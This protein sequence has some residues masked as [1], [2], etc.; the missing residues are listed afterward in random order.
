MIRWLNQILGLCRVHSI[1][2]WGEHLLNIR[3]VISKD[4][5]T[6]LILGINLDNKIDW[7]KYLPWMES[8]TKI[9][10]GPNHSL[11]WASSLPGNPAIK[12]VFS[13]SEK[14]ILYLSLKPHRLCSLSW[15]LWCFSEK[16]EELSLLSSTFSSLLFT[17]ETTQFFFFFFPNHSILTPFLTEA[18]LARST[19]VLCDGIQSFSFCLINQ[20]SSSFTASPCSAW[21]L[22]ECLRAQ[23]GALLLFICAPSFLWWFHSLPSFCWWPFS[24]YLQLTPSLQVAPGDQ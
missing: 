13:D 16:T 15:W 18:V 23:V 3:S 2:F 10:R 17:L 24:V 6:N 22:L 5:I 21:P 8:V 7:R 11:T 1:L 14:T 20:P 4:G 19:Q 12:C 9:P